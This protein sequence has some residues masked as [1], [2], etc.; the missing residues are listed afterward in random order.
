MLSFF[1]ARWRA[2]DPA[3]RL[4]ITVFLVARITLSVWAFTV[5]AFI[6]LAVSNLDLDGEPVVTAFDLGTSA[7]AVFSRMV[8]GKQVLFRAA[9]PNLVDLDTNSV[10]DLNGHAI[11]GA[12]AGAQ[13]SASSYSL[14]QVFP[15]RAVP[16]HQNALL[17]PWQRFDANMYLKIAEY[18]YSDDGSSVYL[19]LYPLLIKVVGD[20]SLGDELLGAILISN[21][22]LVGALFLFY[23]MASELSDIPSAIRALALFSL[24]P[25]A[26]FLMAPYTESLFLFF[27]LV[28]LHEGRR[29][30]W[31]RSGVW[32]ACAALTR[33]QGVLLIVPLTYLAWREHGK[34]A[35]VVSFDALRFASLLLIPL[36]AIA[37][38]AFTNLS[39]FNVYESRL[40]ARFVMPWENVGAAVMLL[41]NGRGSFIDILNLLVTFIFGAMIILSWNRLPRELGL[42][43]VVMFLAPA[44]RMTT[45]QPLVS[46]IRYVLAIF[47]VFI[48]VGQWSDKPWVQRALVYLWFPLQLFLSAQFFLWGWVA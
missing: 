5:S 48:L 24:F 27:V 2:L 23:R 11:S 29:S 40:Q 19:P 4:A 41:A 1:L 16:P 25:T 20:W 26:F 8:D 35:D 42:Y 37:F 45:Q 32:G 14:E 3:W 39:L 36:G 10:W 33:L 34:R 31:G 12:R 21:L 15:Y 28:S 18:G 9:A 13:L 43:S 30:H 44:F 46:M 38:L 47:P 17:A 7:S 22:A 6:P